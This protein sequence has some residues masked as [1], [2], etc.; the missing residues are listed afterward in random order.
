MDGYSQRSR[1]LVTRLT[2]PGYATGHGS[3]FQ[4]HDAY[5]AIVQSLENLPE[6]ATFKIALWFQ[7][8]FSIQRREPGV[9]LEVRTQVKQCM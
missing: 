7:P 5:S 4:I 6:L 1:L 8:S 9:G 3:T 2:T